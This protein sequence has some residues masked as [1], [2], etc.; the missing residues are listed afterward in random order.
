MS[1]APRSACIA[2]G[3]AQ[4]AAWIAGLIK[5]GRVDPTISHSVNVDPWDGI[6]LPGGEPQRWWEK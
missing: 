2:L 4:G 1:S 6:G 3:P 5:K